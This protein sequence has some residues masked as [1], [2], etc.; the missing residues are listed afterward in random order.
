MR[1]AL[2]GSEIRERKKVVREQRVGNLQKK[3]RLSLEKNYE[4]EASRNQSREH[5]KE[6]AEENAI[7]RQERMDFDAPQSGVMFPR[8]E[9][10][11]T[12]ESAKQNKQ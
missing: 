11:K 2:W 6:V 1:S 7:R 3:K 12:R 8:E 5:R 4:K 10:E 9:T